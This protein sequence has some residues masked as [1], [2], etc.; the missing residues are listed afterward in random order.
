MTEKWKLRRTRETSL[1]GIPWDTKRISQSVPSHIK[2]LRFLEVT[3]RMRHSH[4]LG[5]YVD[6]EVAKSIL[7][8]MKWEGGGRKDN[9]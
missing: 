6:G 4:I 9:R 1:F 7:G 3:I 2:I 5:T 8:K